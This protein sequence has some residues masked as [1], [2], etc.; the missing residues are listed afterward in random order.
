MK[1]LNTAS[2]HPSDLPPPMV[3]NK[4]DLDPAGKKYFEDL[5]KKDSIGQAKAADSLAKDT[6]VEP[7]FEEE[8]IPF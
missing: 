4:P 3:Y 8:E 2:T 6:M 5:K 7:E 1:P